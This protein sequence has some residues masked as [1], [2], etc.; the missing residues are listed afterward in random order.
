MTR[1]A[2]IPVT[3]G[4]WSFPGRSARRTRRVG[5][6][7]YWRSVIAVFALAA[8]ACSCG[9]DSDST[10]SPVVVLSAF[11]AEMAAVLAHASVE[12]TV[13]IEDRIFRVGVLGHVPVVIGLTG[14]GLVNAATTAHAVLERFKARGVVFSGVAGSTVQIGDVTVPATWQLS[15]GA[16]YATDPQWLTLANQ[17]AAAGTVSLE[18]CAMVSTAGS[19]QT[20][21]MPQQPT[22]VVGGIGQSSDPFLNKP[23]PCQPDG[24][25]L[26]GCDL[27]AAATPA[28]SRSA[29][30]T[31]DA[32]ANADSAPPTTTDME[33]A[34][35]AA[36]ATARGLPFI[37]FRAVS[38]G[39]GD[40]LKLP[41]F[42]FEFSAYYHFA[43]HNAAAAA[44]AFL[45]RLA[46]GAG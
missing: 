21:C 27:P 19:Q 41:G 40:P 28:A 7:A 29:P 20:V 33:T 23:F 25:D 43:A 39:A 2:A 44:A 42:P 46:D 18:R 36:E 17:I 31:T 8:S 15:G 32:L 6:P 9:G 12:H 26:Y 30:P 45:E 22:I 13:V 5:A 11:P 24:G 14:I 4:R 35:V 10:T 1:R 16:T 3:S 38:D 34:A 37:A